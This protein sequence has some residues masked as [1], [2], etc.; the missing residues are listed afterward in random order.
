MPRETEVAINEDNHPVGKRSRR[1]LYVVYI[2]MLVVSVVILLVGI[3]KGNF[4]RVFVVVPVALILANAIFI[5]RRT[6]HMPPLM[7]FLLV[8]LMVIVI[9]EK[10]MFN[11]NPIYMALTDLV[12]GILL[13]VCGIILT[14]SFV[15]MIFDIYGDKSTKALLVSISVSLSIYVTWLIFQYYIGLA[16]NADKS[17]FTRGFMI[18]TS[19]EQTMNQLTYVIIGILIVSAAFYFGRKSSA[20]KLLVTKYPVLGAT[21]L[22]VEYNEMKGIEKAIEGGECETVEFKSTLRTSLITGERDEMIERAVL[23]TLV[24]FLNSKG[25]LLLIGVEDNG[26]V[27]GIDPS[28]KNRDKAGL[29]LTNLITTHIGNEFLPYISFKVADHKGKE[30]MVVTCTKSHSPVFLKEWPHE[31]FFVRSGS[32]SVELDGANMLKYISNHRFKKEVKR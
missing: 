8:S 9:V 29:H 10:F 32:A 15:T 2:A 11:A 5:D 18:L 31:T 23:K 28:F 7:I 1:I 3:Y 4:L 30:I 24:A 25:G 13:G 22:K 16:V 6:L 27:I 17:P 26:N 12:F 19:M 21:L 20:V 14:Y